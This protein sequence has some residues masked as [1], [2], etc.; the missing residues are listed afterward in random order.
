[1]LTETKMSRNS[2]SQISKRDEKV[3]YFGIDI[4]DI[5]ANAG[6]VGIGDTLDPVFDGSQPNVVGVCC[7]EHC[8]A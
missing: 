7:F 8:E 5:R 2:L 3:E 4:S 1:M 6:I